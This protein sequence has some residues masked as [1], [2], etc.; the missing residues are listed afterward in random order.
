MVIGMDR[1]LGTKFAAKKFNR[2]I[3]NHLLNRRR[4]ASEHSSVCDAHLVYV[5]VG[6][7]STSSL[8]DNQ[9]EVVHE[10]PG[11][12][13]KKSLIRQTSEA[14]D[15]ISHIISCILDGFAYFMI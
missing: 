6:L 12:D 3:R 15:S 5:H 8:E 11:N 2:T 14:C 4:K 10:L 9:G 7:S 1:L 13:L